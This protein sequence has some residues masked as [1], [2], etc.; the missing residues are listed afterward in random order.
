[1]SYKEE[2]PYCGCILTLSDVMASIEAGNHDETI[3]GY[4]VTIDCPDETCE[5]KIK[6]TIDITKVEM[7]EE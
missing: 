2:C 7:V 6:I 4:E 5:R 1:M 3:Y